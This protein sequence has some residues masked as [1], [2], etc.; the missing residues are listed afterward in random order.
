[1]LNC[2]H[3][4]KP[5]W[6][7]HSEPGFWNKTKL[8]KLLWNLSRKSYSLSVKWMHIYYLKKQALMDVKVKDNYIW[9]MKNILK[10]RDGIN[11]IPA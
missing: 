6:T 3:P 10:Q 5:Q 2:L 8:V 9:I 11:L 1:M 7:G 4:Q